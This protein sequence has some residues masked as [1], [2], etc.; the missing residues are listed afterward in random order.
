M[1]PKE[2]EMTQ[3]RGAGHRP[4][5]KAPIIAPGWGGPQG[6]CLE[7]RFLPAPLAARSNVAS[8]RGAGRESR[9]DARNLRVFHDGAE[10]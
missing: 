6:H 5:V 1:K 8:R 7:R 3:G 2:R 9:A 10:V 4:D